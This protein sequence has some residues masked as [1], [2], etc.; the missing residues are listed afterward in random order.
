MK[1]NNFLKPRKVPPP[2]LG[3]YRV[4]WKFMRIS[5]LCDDIMLRWIAIFALPNS[6]KYNL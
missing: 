1:K 4:P 6:A 5:V 3:I 2:N